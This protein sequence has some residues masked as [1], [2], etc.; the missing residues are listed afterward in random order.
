MMEMDAQ[1]DPLEVVELVAYVGNGVYY[2]V[3]DGGVV[4]IPDEAEV[5]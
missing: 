1:I 4:D 2:V 3:E 5:G